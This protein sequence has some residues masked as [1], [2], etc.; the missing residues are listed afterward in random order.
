[1]EGKILKPARVR[2]FQLNLEVLL[3]LVLQIRNKPAIIE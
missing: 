1:M 2:Y 3:D